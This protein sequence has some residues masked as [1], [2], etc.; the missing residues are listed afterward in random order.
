MDA[1]ISRLRPSV[2][3][4]KLVDEDF[5]KN[6]TGAAGVVFI[7]KTAVQVI[8]GTRAAQIKDAVDQEMARLKSE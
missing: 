4:K 7:G 1:C 6:Q 2:K 5:L 3:D 8:Y